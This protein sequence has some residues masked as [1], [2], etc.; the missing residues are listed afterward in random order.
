MA[1][2]KKLPSG[3]WRIQ[4][5]LGKDTNGKPIRASFTAPTK[6][7]A[8]LQ[9]A[10]YV[11]E[12]QRYDFRNITVEDA[13]DR[14]IAAKT[15]VL[16][17][18]TIRAYRSYQRNYYGGIGHMPISK[19]NTE[20]MQL[21][22]SSMV[23][24]VSN[25]TIHNAYGLLSSAIAL[26]R[27]DKVFRVTLPTKKATRRE[28]PS[29]GVV[30][31][32]YEKAGPELQKCIALAAFGSLRRGEICALKHQDVTGQAVHVHADMIM[33]EHGDWIYKDIPKTAESNRVVYLP[34][35]VIDLLGDGVD[36]EYI[37]SISPSRVSDR[38]IKLRERL[39]LHGVRFHDLRHY[40]ASIGAVLGIPDTYLSQ[41]GGWRSD[42]PVMKSI[43]Q[44]VISCEQ[45][46]FS[47]AMN[48]HFSG[49]IKG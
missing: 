37:I 35:E 14:Y 45:Q 7:E 39:G 15:P 44:N 2:A 29:D 33:D 36:D 13:I 46:K 32:L 23:G 1:T 47:Q 41:F 16:S 48:A 40:Y 38:F 9:A 3:M 19:L 22:V 20:E 6:K 30:R 11:A 26:F 27:P 24:T 49:V 31:E 43:Y 17:P 34:Q 4:A 25:K 10:Q 21:F 42:S 18:S 12:N 5:Y 8:E 28:S